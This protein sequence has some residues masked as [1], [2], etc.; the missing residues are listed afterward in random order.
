[1]NKAAIKWLTILMMSVSTRLVFA[2]IVDSIPLSEPGKIC[3]PQTQLH[4]KFPVGSD[5]PRMDQVMLTHYLLVPEQDRFKAGHV[6]VGFRLQN[7]PGKLWLFNGSSWELKETA[8]ML[9]F[10]SDNDALRNLEDYTGREVVV[11][12]Q[13]VIPIRISNYPVDVSAFVGDGELLVG[14]GLSSTG[15][16]NLGQEAFDEMMANNRFWRIWRVGE[17]HFE[18]VPGVRTGGLLETICLEASKIHIIT[19]TL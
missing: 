1:M 4:A 7:Q 6:F 16:D 18:Q 15:D 3:F 14:Y 11:P 13:P 5:G 2:H 9:N 8:I 17:L 10:S 12:L 19:P